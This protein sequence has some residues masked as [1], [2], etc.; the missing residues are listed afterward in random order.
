MKKLIFLFFI[1]FLSVL[2]IAQPISLNPKNPHYFLFR[3]KPLVIVS[4]GEHYGAVLNPSFDF[5]RYLNT[6]QNDGMNY[7]RMFT[8]TYFEKDGS[9]G[10]EKNTLA[11]ASGMALVPWKRSKEPGAVCGGNKFDLDQWDNS[12]FTRLKNFVSE[13]GKRGIIVEV[14]LFSSIYDYWSI[15]PWNPSNNIN[16]KEDLTKENVQTLKNGLALKY[17]ENVVRKIVNDLNEFDNVIFEIQN[18]PWSDHTVSIQPDKEFFNNEDFKLDGAEWQK[19]IDIADKPSL[20]WQKKIESVIVDEEMKLKNKHLIAQNFSNFYYPVAETDP[21]ISIMNFHYAYP[22]AVEKNYEHLK[23]IGFDESGFAGNADATYRKQAWKFIIAG[24]GLFNNLDY[25]FAI[26]K[27]DGTAVNKA[28]GGGSPELRKQFKVL[29]DFIQSFDFVKM[30]PDHSTIVLARGSF[31]RALS[32]PGKQYAIYINT[33]NKCNLKISLPS[34]NYESKWINTLNGYT[35]KSET[36]KHSGG[37]ITLTS[38]DFSEDIA[39][40]ITLQ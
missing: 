36:L 8:G 35:L 17:Q 30:K 15:Q 23:V 28:P 6:L 34:G 7:T 5:I 20:D 38:P 29:S 12:Y 26:G 21:N 4:S 25:S 1:S 14:S 32:E 33:G 19:R 40:K 37:T 13:A 11:P 9:F 24:G 31:A 27:E 3:G 39:L 10:I 22:I 16:I 18:E 2:L